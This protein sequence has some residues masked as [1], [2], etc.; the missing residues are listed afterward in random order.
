MNGRIHLFKDFSCRFCTLNC[1]VGGI[2]KLLRHKH[3]RVFRFHLHCKRQTFLYAGSDVSRIVNENDFRSVMA[4]KLA[5]FLA[6]RIG[7]N[8][9][10]LVSP[11]RSDKSKPYALIAACRLDYH[12]VGIY[13][14]LFFGVTYHIE[15]RARLN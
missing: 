6:D 5:P 14:P 11:D 4:D 2:F 10:Y 12:G 8:N 13:K 15:S 1:G 3:I 9:F 7:H